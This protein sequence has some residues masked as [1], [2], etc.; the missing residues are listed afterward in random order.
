MHVVQN[1]GDFLSISR[2]P[3]Q[4]SGQNIRVTANKLRFACG[5]SI[6]KCYQDRYLYYIL[7]NS[8]KMKVLRFKVP[9]CSFFLQCLNHTQIANLNYLPEIYNPNFDIKYIISD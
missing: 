6:L 5:Q 3:T 1:V 9:D 8:K 2:T 4:P 7:N